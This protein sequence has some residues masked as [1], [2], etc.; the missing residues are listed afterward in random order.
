MFR[1]TGF[2]FRTTL[3]EV[4]TLKVALRESVV[5]T[6]EKPKSCQ[7]GHV[8]EDG[9]RGDCVMRRVQSFFVPAFVVV[10]LLLFL[11]SMLLADVT[12]SILGVVRDPSSAV[13]KGAK[14]RVTNTDTNFSEQTATADDGSYRF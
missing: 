3:S 13:V 7:G 5:A 11:P 2:R 9:H 1:A 8:E 12:G 4:R 10:S 14:I 6:S